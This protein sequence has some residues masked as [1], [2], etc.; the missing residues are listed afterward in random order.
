MTDNLP[1]VK[2]A[3]AGKRFTLNVEWRDG[4]R[5]KVD[6]TGLVHSSRHFRTFADDPEAFRHVKPDEFGTGIEWD[7]GLD[8][9][10]AS[11]KT[12][13]DEQKP[14]SGTHLRRF[15]AAR[16]LNTHETARLFDVTD[17]TIQALRKA[18]ELPAQFSIALRRFQKDPTIFAAHY[19][20]IAVKPRGRPKVSASDR[21]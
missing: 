11:L 6:L 18:S 4:T 5:A 20:P 3:A 10:A 16:G 7:N 12:L 2:S 15:E 8:Y 21:R 1:R 17:R 13:A 14:M 9:S 19:R